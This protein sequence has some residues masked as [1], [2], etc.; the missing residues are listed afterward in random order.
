MSLKGVL[1]DYASTLDKFF[2]VMTAIEA[3]GCEEGVE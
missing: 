1:S 3:G 2:T